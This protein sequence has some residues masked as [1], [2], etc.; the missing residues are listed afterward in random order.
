MAIYYVASY[1]KDDLKG[2]YLIDYV[3]EQLSLIGHLPTKDYPSYLI[4]QEDKIYAS[5]KDAS[6]KKNGGGVACFS[7]QED[8]LT[9]TQKIDGLGISYTHLCIS[10]EPA[11]LFTANYHGGTT[12]SYQLDTPSY[13]IHC[14]EHLGSGPDALQRQTSAHVHCVGITPDKEYLFAVDLG[15]DKVVMYQYKEGILKENPLLSL[16][17]TPG[18]GPRHLIFSDDGKFAYLVNEISNSVCVYRYDG[19]FHFLQELSTLPNDYQEVSSASAIKLS[20]D[21]KHLFI[22]NRGHNSIMAYARN[23]QTGLLTTL[24]YTPVGNCPR[25]IYITENNDILVGAQDDNRIEVYKF[26]VNLKTITPTYHYL[27]I[28][29]PVCIIK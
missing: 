28:P 6:N 10:D 15:S 12:S 14:K 22:S 5:L 17:V 2:I 4:K 27:E 3:D 26:N 9:F 7:I 20:N 13:P 25:D 8:A 19:K 11:Y 24:C 1:G 18:S 23:N 21:N 29:Q 16:H